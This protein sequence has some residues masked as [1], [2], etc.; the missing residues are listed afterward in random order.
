M[1][2]YVKKTD[3]PRMGRPKIDIDIA[4]FE[5][6]CNIQCTKEEIAGWFGCS[7]DTIENFC[8]KN[9]KGTFSAV[10]KSLSGKG[11][12]SLRRNQ[13]KL[14]ETNVTMAIFLGKQYLGQSDKIETVNSFEDLKPLADMLKL[15]DKGNAND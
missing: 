10:F 2:N 5:K 7:E 14:S 8:K 9:Y 12:V 6:L 4:Q 11:K 1:A 13:F 3:N 15:E